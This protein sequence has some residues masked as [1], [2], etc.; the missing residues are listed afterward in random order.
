M[1]HTE[2]VAK[3]LNEGKAPEDVEISLSLS[4]IKLLHAK[5]IYEMYEYF[6]GRIDLVLNGFESE[7]IREVLKNSNDVFE[8]IENPF[9]A[10][11]NDK[12]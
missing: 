3:Q 9:F 8:T 2:Q 6:R 12:N 4:E 10:S 7:W 1:R 5:W 11:A